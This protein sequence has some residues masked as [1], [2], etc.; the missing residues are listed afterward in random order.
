MTKSDLDQPF[1]RLGTQ[2]IKWDHL[3]PN[4]PEDAL[5]LW[6]ADMDFP[7]AEPILE[8]LHKRI[9]QKIFG[10]TEYDCDDCKNAITGWFHRR[11]NWDIPIKDIFFSAAVIP[12]M[13]YLID[14]LTET[15]DGILIQRPVYYP[16]T[17]IILGGGRRV[18]NN[19]L[20]LCDGSYTMDF[21]DLDR[22]MSEPGTKGMILCSPHNPVGR[23]WTKT[24]L[25][26][27]V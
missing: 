25:K 12:A 19:P 27:V 24:E 14:A 7:C 15:G 22:K 17:N 4:T 26:K 6:V 16:F 10:Y 5:P 2:C 3:L 23:V 11:F 21:D 9:D 8:A 13:A 18:I 20:T 1:N